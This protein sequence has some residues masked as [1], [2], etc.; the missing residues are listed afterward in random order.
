MAEAN[1]NMLLRAGITD[2]LQVSNSSCSSS[3]IG[4]SSSMR[5]SSSG[6]EEVV[7]DTVARCL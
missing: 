2:I 5:N 1:K 7:H 6:S 4:G 3:S